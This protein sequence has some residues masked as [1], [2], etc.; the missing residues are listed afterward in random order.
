MPQADT[1]ILSVKCDLDVEMAR[2]LLSALPNCILIRGMT[3]HGAP[4]WL[5]IGLQFLALET[6]RQRP[7]SLYLNQS[8]AGYVIH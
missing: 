6:E 8:L 7:G 1:L 4:E 2:P 3:D 5:K